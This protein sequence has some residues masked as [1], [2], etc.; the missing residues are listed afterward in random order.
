MEVTRQGETQKACGL[1]T[2]GSFPQTA[3]YHES[4][5]S[6]ASILDEAFQ[7]SCTLCTEQS[8]RSVKL[9]RQKKRRWV[10]TAAHHTEREGHMWYNCILCAC[11]YLSAECIIE[12]QAAIAVKDRQ[13]VI[14]CQPN[15]LTSSNFRKKI[16][17]QKKSWVGL[18]ISRNRTD[19]NGPKCLMHYFMKWNRRYSVFLRKRKGETE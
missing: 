2:L 4:N 17:R 9:W 14:G 6:R 8:I 12:L 18:R 15:K 5:Q 3:D 1:H 7:R 11:S 16:G 10:S 13:V 19:W